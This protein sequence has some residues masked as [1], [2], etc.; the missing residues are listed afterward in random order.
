MVC[1]AFFF[2]IFL[3]LKY[4]NLTAW[5]YPKSP[6]NALIIWPHSSCSFAF[7][8]GSRPFQKNK[9][10]LHPDYTT[11]LPS[12]VENSGGIVKRF[13][14]PLHT[15]ARLF[16]CLLQPKKKIISATKHD[17][18]T[19]FCFIFF[20]LSIIPTPNWIF[21]SF[22]WVSFVLNHPMTITEK[23]QRRIC[24]GTRSFSGVQ[25]CTYIL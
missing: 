3:F 6:A 17:R 16:R 14:P 2:S 10:C 21:S 15:R 24:L 20:G 18:N 23:F 22:P 25:A 7:H 11:Y 4:R 12:A 1:A 19:P 13:S 5:P 9:T 8:F